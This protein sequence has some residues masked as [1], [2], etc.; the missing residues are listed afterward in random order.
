MKMYRVDDKM[1]EVIVERTVKEIAKTGKPVSK[2]K[3]FEKIFWG[4]VARD[5]KV[6]K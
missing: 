3:T 4:N 5:I 1:E 6:K 2:Q